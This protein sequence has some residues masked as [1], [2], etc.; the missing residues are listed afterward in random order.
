MFLRAGCET[1]LLGGGP[2]VEKSVHGI[3]AARR[4]A[5]NQEE[6]WSAPHL[7]TF[8]H[9]LSGTNSRKLSPERGKRR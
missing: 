7:E 6:P 5:A 1:R 2:E 4:T 9:G 8:L 3:A